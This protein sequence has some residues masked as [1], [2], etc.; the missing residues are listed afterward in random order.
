[1]RNKLLLASFAVLLLVLIGSPM[2]AGADDP[3][4]KIEG[5]VADTSGMSMEGVTV[6]VAVAGTDG[7]SAFQGVTDAVGFFSVGAAANTNLTISFA[8]FGYRVLTC[9]NVSIQQGSDYHSLNLT[10]ATYASATRTYTITGPV[11]AMQCAIMI[12]SD[13]DVRG[14]VSFDK[15]PIRNATVTFTPASG[16][17][18]HTAHTDDRGYYEITCPIG[19]YAMTASSQGFNRSDPI[20]VDVKVS[21]ST[22]NVTLE[23]SELR[24]YLGMDAAHILMLVGVILGMMLAVAAWLLGKHMNRPHSLEIIDDSAEEDSDVKH[25]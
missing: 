21:L 3:F 17:T 23:K 10:T 16:G 4:Y 13:G 12:A 24:K 7:S 19:T 18:T 20:T 8:V 25:P 11:G 1:M 6:S 15:A 22:V 2:S 5:Y 9:P 14:T